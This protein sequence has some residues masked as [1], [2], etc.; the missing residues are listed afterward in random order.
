MPKKVQ[1]T[2]HMYVCYMIIDIFFVFAIVKGVV[3]AVGMIIA[4][5]QLDPSR[6]KEQIKAKC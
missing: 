4:V 2:I 6:M 3:V 1:S 5:L